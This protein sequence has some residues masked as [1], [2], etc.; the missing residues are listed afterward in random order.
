MENVAITGAGVISSVGLGLDGFIDGLEAGRTGT[1]R[2]PWARPD[3]G[4]HAWYSPV[5]DFDPRR[6]LD[7]R[8]VTGTVEFSQYAVIAA[9]QALE[10]A[11]LEPSSD[12]GVVFGTA[13]AGASALAGAQH[14]LETEGPAAVPRKLQI[15]AWANL[16]AGHIAM[17]HGLHGP[18]MTVST[19]CAAGL[20]ALGYAV[21][22]VRSGE[23]DVVIAGGSEHAFSEVLYQAQLNY[24][25]SGGVEDPRLAT[26][27][28]D[29]RRSGLVEGAGAAMF[30]LEGLDHARARG[31][32]VLG[33]V[34]GYANVSDAFH[35][36]APEPSGRWEAESMMRA[37]R[38]AGCEPADVDGIVAHA[39][40]TPKG[41]DAEI[42][43]INTVFGDRP[44]SLH[45]TSLKGNVGHTGGA[46]GAMG[47]AVALH[48]LRSG[49]LPHL[50][51]TEQPEPAARFHIVTERPTVADFSV[52]QVNSF[53]FAGQDS[54]MV[55]RRA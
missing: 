15:Q 36:S 47:V 26:M 48:V 6:W 44:D 22:L 32:E 20:D 54:S 23:A 1:R 5:P 2:A 51:T 43:A 12:T 33:V 18:L 40:S 13:M 3:E 53:G 28:F 25:M 38:Q 37:I 24:G 41:D 7:E 17:R 10:M 27:P 9:D 14:L 19:A 39:T 4:R 50:P 30:V 16:A 55:L 46:S 45:V 52:I 34:S 49:R 31:A 29:T 8:T 42:A 21:R 35:P 11:G